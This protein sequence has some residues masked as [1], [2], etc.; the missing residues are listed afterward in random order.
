M[1]NRRT[2]KRTRKAPHPPPNRS[3]L[4]LKSVYGWMDGW[5]TYLYIDRHS[6]EV[7]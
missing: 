7:E 1:R 4:H 2:H 5:A 3:P 6:K